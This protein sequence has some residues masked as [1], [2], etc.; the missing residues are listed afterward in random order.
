M[1]SSLRAQELNW[2]RSAF[3]EVSVRLTRTVNKHIKYT[4]VLGS[5]KKG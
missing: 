4:V 5:W 1:P 2:V 3:L